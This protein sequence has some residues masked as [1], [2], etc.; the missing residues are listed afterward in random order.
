V[1]TPHLND[2]HVVFGEVISGKSVVR[3]IENLPTQNDKPQRDAKINGTVIRRENP[4]MT[5]LPLFPLV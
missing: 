5:Q 3:K 2:K 1:P 4:T